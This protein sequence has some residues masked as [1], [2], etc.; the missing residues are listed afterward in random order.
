MRWARGIIVALGLSFAAVL[1]LVAQ[2]TAPGAQAPAQETV[3]QQAPEAGKNAAPAAQ[4]EAPT[5]TKREG[6]EISEQKKEDAAERKT[7][8]QPGENQSA[9]PADNAAPK[10]RDQAESKTSEPKAEPKTDDKA[11]SPAEAESNA[12]P[13]QESTA[14][15]G[16][17]AVPGS[18]TART[19]GA[20][21]GAASSGGAGANEA[22]RLSNP[23]P[24]PTPVPPKK[25]RR[26]VVREGGAS[27]PVAQIVTGMTVEEASSERREAE[28]FLDAA[29]ENLRRVTGRTLDA[30][31]QET[32]SQIH[33]YVEHARSALK[34]GDISRGHTLA[35]KANLLADDLVKH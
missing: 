9:K 6:K 27:E 25:P 24:V 8:A 30:Q 18:R 31:Q 3:K 4:G 35:L 1:P 10:T 23:P 7:D 21:A 33:N 2:N 13:D 14:G 20:D 12:K 16:S 19:S 29:E 26:V 28:K 22:H 34:E 5:E 32:I 11:E 17:S 15:T